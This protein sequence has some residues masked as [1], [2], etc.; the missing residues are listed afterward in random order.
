MLKPHFFLNTLPTN[1]R[2]LLLFFF[3]VA[4]IVQMRECKREDDE[5]LLNIL[6]LMALRNDRADLLALLR[7]S[8]F[9]FSGNSYVIADRFCS[10]RVQNYLLTNKVGLEC[11]S[12]GADS[13]IYNYLS[14]IL[15]AYLPR[16]SKNGR[17]T[18]RT[19]FR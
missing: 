18:L 19:Q 3:I 8:G 13:T 15:Q 10:S 7:K 16:T 11:L 4:K 12:R 9:V 17:L 5:K 2:F 1:R 6:C 14:P